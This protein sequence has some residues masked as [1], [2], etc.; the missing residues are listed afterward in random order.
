[1]GNIIAGTKAS[2]TIRVR[3]IGLTTASYFIDVKA[4][5]PNGLSLTNPKV[6]KFAHN[7]N[8]IIEMQLSYTTKRSMRSG[9]VCFKIPMVIDNGPKYVIEVNANIIGKCRRKTQITFSTRTTRFVES[10]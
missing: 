8:N 3:N 4:L 9:P 5:K 7:T 1:L 10:D 2:K 6:S